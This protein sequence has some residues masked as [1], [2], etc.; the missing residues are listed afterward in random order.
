VVGPLA[1]ID[2]STV[3]GPAQIDLLIALERQIAWLNAAQQRVLA[4]LDGRAL[5]WSGKE[6]VDYTEE[7]VGAALRLSPGT[8][9]TRLEVG[10][11]LVE[12]LPGT[13]AMLERGEITYLHAKKLAG[14]VAD[15]D[16]KATATVEER[17]LRRAAQQTVGQFGSAVA[18]AV[19]AA[20]P[21]E[22][23]E[24]RDDAV[25][26]RRVVMTPVTDGMAV[27]WAL[28]PAEGAAL[29]KAVLDS[30][31]AA[32]APGETRTA[33]QRRADCL[34]D[35][36]ARVVGDPELPQQHGRRAAVQVTVALSTLLSCDENPAELDG[37]GPITAQA[38]RRIAA[39]ETS[40]W[41]RLVTDPVNGQ[42]VEL[43]RS[44]YRPPRDL[45]DYVRARDRRCV[46]PG[47]R[48]SAR[49][50]EIDHADPWCTGGHTCEHNLHPLCTRH[51]HAKH[52][53][54]WQVRRLDDGSFR[55]T[56]PTGHIHIV[57]PPDDG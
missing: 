31:A 13:L 52:N 28:L 3:D 4:A 36:F 2:P 21:R 24:R 5:D 1:V 43:G 37:Y 48:R 10:R 14:A 17:V 42:L 40:T 7:Q 34:V 45:A 12:Q 22:A 55:W 16:P 23:D 53:A 46:F 30:L 54:G 35:V 41:Q 25:E 27:L 26:Q 8:A 49:H 33:D 50:C 19:I 29:I 57:P 11:T 15:L 6:S 44:T 18:R 39:D 9:A 38:A 51:H 32:K 56:A 47:C 20:D